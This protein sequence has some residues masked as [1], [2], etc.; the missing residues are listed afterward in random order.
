MRPLALSASV[1]GVAAMG[2]AALPA[3]AAAPSSTAP[4]SAAASDVDLEVARVAIFTSGVAY[5]ERQAEVDGDGSAEIRFRTE[6]INDVL[7]SLVVQD[8]GGKPG[9]V[10]YASRDP[11]SR[12]LKSFAV[13]LTDKPTLGQLLDQLRGEPVELG[14]SLKA[15]GVIVGVET[16]FVRLPNGEV[17]GE[18]EIL[19]LLTDAGL[20]AFEL[21]KLQTIK[22]VNA[23]IDEEL[24]KALMTL[25]SAHDAD[26]KSVQVTFEGDGK[27]PVRVA[28]MLEA[29]V[30][31]TSYRL[32]LPAEGKPLVQGWATVENATESD[33]KNV[34]LTLVSGRPV[35]FRMDLYTPLYVPRPLEMMEMFAGLRPPTYETAMAGEGGGGEKLN[36]ESDGDGVRAGLYA[37]PA[38]AAAP[39]RARAAGR[40]VMLGNSEFLGSPSDAGFAGQAAVATGAEAGE[41]FSYTIDAPVSI[42]RQQSAM[43]PIVSGPID[44]NKVS[45]FNV[46]THARHAFNGLELKNTTGLHLMQG[47]I[48]VFDGGSYAGDAK[49]LDLHPDEQRLI[50]YALDLATE[51]DVKQQPQPEEIVSLWIRKGVLFHKRRYVDQRVYEVKNKSD[52]PKTVIL[53]QAT[54][55]EW[56]LVEPKEAHQRTR[57]TLRFKLPVEGRKTASQTVTLERTAEQAVGLVDRGL[58]EI[59]FYMRSR[60]IS[61]QVRAALEEVAQRR[62]DLDQIARRRAE[63]EKKREELVADQARIRENLKTLD[64]AQDAY[65]RQLRQFDDIDEQINTLREEIAKLR[66]D[67]A[68]KRKALE[69]YLAGLDVG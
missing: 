56:S 25:A 51:V 30:W 67:E 12:T 42:A 49:M 48:T 20:Q 27:R 61:P 14:G 50:A 65:Q 33:W 58:D 69:D 62:T 22:L 7:K 54:S 43:L 16:K 59:A 66:G 2:V 24:R 41:L 9:I 26:K 32:V 39:A 53:E 21:A 17:V 37:T 19:T 47:P 68:A 31:K 4:P 63:A 35:S 3:F 13:D 5:Y 40:G 29:P 28:Y 38:P 64:K 52:K 45:I 6:Q 44:A 55:D 15:K 1:L 11:I 23:S 60:T 46:A 34:Q 36:M 10:R 18:V 57:D 8:A